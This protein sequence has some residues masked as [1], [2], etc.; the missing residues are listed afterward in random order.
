MEDVRPVLVDQD[1]FRVVIVKGIAGD[2]LALVDDQDSFPG[3]GC[4][5]LGQH[6]PGEP[7][8]DDQVVER[9]D[10]SGPVTAAIFFYVKVHGDAGMVASEWRVIVSFFC[11]SS[12]LAAML[13]SIRV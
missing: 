5:A 13:D 12:S 6:A 11:S 3:A 1:A 10:L 9:L 7:G 2:V 8:A 4:Q